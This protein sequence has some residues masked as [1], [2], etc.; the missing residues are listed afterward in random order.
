[1]LSVEPPPPDHPLLAPDI[2]NLV[3]T[4]HVAWASRAARQR[5]IDA[6]AAN[7]QDFATR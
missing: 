2:P 7:I 1:M 4:P 5:L 6:V 3:L